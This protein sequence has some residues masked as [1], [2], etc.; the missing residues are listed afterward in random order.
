MA[1]EVILRFG[2]RIVRT[3]PE[4]L[5]C[6]FGRRSDV[7]FIQIGAHDG[8]SDDSIF[9]F[10]RGRGWRGI[11]VEP[12]R[13][14]FDR[15]TENYAGAAGVILENKALAEQDG[16]VTFYSVKQTSDEVPEWYDQIGSLKRDVILSHQAS[17]PNIA[18]YLAEIQV[19]AISFDT[20]VAKHNVTHVDLILIDT[21]GYDLNIL[22]TINLDRFRP[23]LIIFEQ[24]HLT[25][26]GKAEAVR[27]LASHGYVVHGF[28]PNAAATRT[29]YWRFGYWWPRGRGS[30]SGEAA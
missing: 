20:L 10:A 24:K 19:E 4:W 6:L 25:S 12:V 14:L 5:A 8:I 28:G 30:G 15:L 16:V 26:E 29:A 21:E 1:K 3:E 7:F 9:P 23:T 27:M 17:I 13:Y 18:D 22:R 2:G 11:L